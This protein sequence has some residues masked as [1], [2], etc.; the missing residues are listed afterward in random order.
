MGLTS[1]R[2]VMLDAVMQIQIGEVE[3]IRGVI[4]VQHVRCVLR[5]EE[6]EGRR[7]V[8]GGTDFAVHLVESDIFAVVRENTFQIESDV[9]SRSSADR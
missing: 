3:G 7:E 6:T 1:E 8:V 9:R 4:L 5:D 2:G